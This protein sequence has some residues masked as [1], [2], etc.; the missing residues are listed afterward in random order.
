[1]RKIRVAI[2]GVGNCTSSLIQGV[3]YYRG[4][5]ENS[6]FVPGV[7]HNVFGGYKIGDI[8]FVAAFD[9][10]MNKVGKDLSE[11]I[12]TKPNCATKF[13]SIKK[14]G[15][16]VEKGEVL[17]GLGENLKRIIQIDPDA[18]E[19]N[20]SDVLKERK[21]D[22]LINYL[23][24]GSKKASEYYAEQCLIAGCGFIN[25]IP[26]VIATSAE[27]GKKFK[28]AGLP[29]LGDDIKSQLG[30]TI[31]HRTLIELFTKRG[32]KIEKS[33]IFN[34]GGNTDFYNLSEES[35]SET[36]LTSKKA[37]V[38]SLVP[39]PASINVMPSG[40]VDFWGDYKECHIMI[41]GKKCGMTPVKIEVKLCVEDSPNSA[42][43]MVDIIR[44]TKVALDRGISGPIVDVCGYYFKNPPE[45]Y[46]E[47]EAYDRVQKFV[48]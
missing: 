18:K 25:G 32:V 42:G 22:L 21:T 38:Q 30:G 41:Q 36:K 19:V 13:S 4:V 24:T 45:S 47:N 8:E 29:L 31:L 34:V 10:D 46:S 39:Y 1:M 15:V 37:A 16:K 23:P 33:Y 35:R 5:D 40:Y 14:L 12:F 48:G 28:D 6:G 44:A 3:E 20:V 27:W 9:V 17:D 11:A 7:A 2:A 26:E 43:V